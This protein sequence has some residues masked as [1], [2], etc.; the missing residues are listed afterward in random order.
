M[1]RRHNCRTARRDRA[2]W[3]DS[4]ATERARIACRERVLHELGDVLA[5]LASVANQLGLS[6]EDAVA[7]YV[8]GRGAWPCGYP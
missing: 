4:A 7:R 8:S 3:R 2:I 6:V 1:R 5:W